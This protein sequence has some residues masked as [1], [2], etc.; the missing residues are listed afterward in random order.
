MAKITETASYTVELTGRE[1]ALVQ[2]ALN[3][4]RTYGDPEEWDEAA[5]LRAAL[6]VRQ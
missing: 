6:E 2:R 3:L 5:E 4:V 1:L